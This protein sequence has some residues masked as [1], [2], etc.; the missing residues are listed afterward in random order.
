MN[1]YSLFLAS[2]IIVFDS[3]F[4]CKPHNKSDTITRNREQTNSTGP[5]RVLI[6]MTMKHHSNFVFF[7]LPLLL[8]VFFLVVNVPT[9]DAHDVFK[10]LTG[11]IDIS[12][13]FT[14][15]KK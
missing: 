6:W 5:K 12:D 2:K 8:L 9:I 14:R 1:K 4:V 15:R 3:K 10:R 11:R 7:F 13:T